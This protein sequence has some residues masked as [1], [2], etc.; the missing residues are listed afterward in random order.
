MKRSYTPLTHT[1]PAAKR[2]RH[3]NH[4]ATSQPVTPPTRPQVGAKRTREEGNADWAADWEAA[5]ASARRPVGDTVLRLAGKRPRTEATAVHELPA[6][7]RLL[8]EGQHARILHLTRTLLRA[9]QRE[10]FLWRSLQTLA[11][12]TNFDLSSLRPGIPCQ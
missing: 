3:G 11:A 8:L 1:T 5:E 2:P 7:V 9:E 10:S 6:H 4:A 12:R